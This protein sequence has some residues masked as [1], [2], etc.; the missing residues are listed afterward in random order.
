MP[1]PDS[2]AARGGKYSAIRAIGKGAYG[3]VYYAV[4]NLGRQVAVKEALPSNLEFEHARAKFQTE[5]Q[6]QAAFRHPNILHVYHL[7]DDPATHELYLIGE[8]ANGGSLADHL[9]AHGPLSEREAAL[10]A[11]DICRALAETSS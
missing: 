1:F 11:R 6:I 2:V 4:D 8:Y 3:Q 10:V 7:E 9:E 5:A